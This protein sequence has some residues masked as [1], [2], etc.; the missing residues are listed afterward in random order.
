MA[1]HSSVNK[2]ADKETPE[3]APSTITRRPNL[4]RRPG[5]YKPVEEPA[6]PLVDD[7]DDS[8]EPI[9]KSAV[10]PDPEDTAEAQ[11]PAEAVAPAKVKRK[12][13]T[14][15]EMAAAG[16]PRSLKLAVTDSDSLRKQ[17]RQLEG[18]LLDLRMQID[19]ATARFAPKLEKLRAKH[20]ELSAQLADSLVK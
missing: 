7:D 13:R 8:V 1:L 9:A 14:K 18:D 3:K 19:K 15:E 6:S 5:I 2:L 11:E 10:A 17:L 4:G 12:R 16:T 20:A